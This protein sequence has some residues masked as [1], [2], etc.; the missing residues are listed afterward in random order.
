[1][2][3][4]TTFMTFHMFFSY[5]NQYD[6]VWKRFKRKISFNFVNQVQNVQQQ[7]QLQSY[8]ISILK[9]LAQ[10]KFF[11][12]C[13]WTIKVAWNK[14]EKPANVHFRLQHTIKNSFHWI[15][16]NFN[17]RTEGKT[18]R[19]LVVVLFS[20]FEARKKE[21]SVLSILLRLKKIVFFF[22]DPFSCSKAGQ[23]KG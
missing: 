10:E 16:I 4:T 12:V 9:F 3:V 8:I 20:S 7:A 6:M 19:L 15:C 11:S 22:L 23:S 5:P 1:M 18:F 17:L 2:C 21:H 13:F 14:I